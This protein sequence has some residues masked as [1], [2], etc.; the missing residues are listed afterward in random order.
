MMGL[1]HALLKENTMKILQESDLSN[2][3]VEA[4]GARDVFMRILVG[5]RDGSDEIIMRLFTVLPGGHTPLHQH[6]W[7]H[8][9]RVENG[10]G[11]AVDGDGTQ[12]ELQP[13]R[14]VFIP[15]N[16]EHQFRNPSSQGFQFICVIPNANAKKGR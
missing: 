12:H 6:D 3:R 15:A 10:R 13:G 2:D 7:E 16:E 8:L 11:V 14:C 9:V 5:P 1:P 4:E